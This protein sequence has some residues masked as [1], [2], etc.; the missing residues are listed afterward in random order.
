[1]IKGFPPIVGAEAKILILGSMPSVTSLK[2]VEYYG[3]KH[4][5]FWKIIT[6]Y[7][8][9]KFNS[10]TDK[11]ECLKAHGIAL[12][13]VI[14]SCEREGSLDSKIRNVTVNPIADFVAIHPSIKAIFCNG[15]KSYE[16]YQRHF[17]SL[18]ISCICLPSTSNANRIIKECDLYKIWLDSLK[19]YL[20][21]DNK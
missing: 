3:Y 8:G 6:T 18:S 16:L 20:T 4:N 1:M 9:C 12:W 5:R 7:T 14:E 15:K 17:S 10:Y 19:T 2:N 21:N 13:D 11:E